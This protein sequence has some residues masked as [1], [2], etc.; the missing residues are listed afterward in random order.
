MP[1]SANDLGSLGS[2]SRTR[3]RGSRVCSCRSAGP[4]RSPGPDGEASPST[5]QA[6]AVAAGAACMH[7]PRGREGAQAVPLSRATLNTKLPADTHN[8]EKAVHP[9]AHAH[10]CIMPMRIRA[11][12]RPLSKGLCFSWP[13]CRTPKVTAKTRHSSTMHELN[14]TTTTTPTDMLTSRFLAHR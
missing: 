12:R 10:S 4:A 3:K 9:P 11:S 5:R 14:T 1:L 2:S 7:E 6:R 8:Y 13:I